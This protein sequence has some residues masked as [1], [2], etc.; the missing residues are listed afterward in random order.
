MRVLAIDQGT[1]ATKALVVE[2]DGTVAA[3]VEVPV[4][5]RTGADGAVEVD[6]EE[7]W[8]SVLAA[9]AAAAGERRRRVRR[10]RRP[11][12]PGRDHPGLGAVERGAPLDRHRLA[13][14]SRRGRVRA[15]AADGWSERLTAITG[16]ELDPYFVAPKVAWL[17]EQLWPERR[18]RSSPITTTDAWLLHRLCGGGFVTDAATASR[19]LLLDLDRVAWSDEA[20]GAVRHRRGRAP[21]HR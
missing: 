20:V 13:G 6:P 14:P 9:G 8:S 2:D 12:Q 10:W 1:S 15:A 17:R 11:G 4:A 19:T 18:R 5:V 7:L 3:E 21:R 16:L